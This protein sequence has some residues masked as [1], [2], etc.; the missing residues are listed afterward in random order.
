MIIL[1]DFGLSHRKSVSI[2]M[3][4]F[5]QTADKCHSVTDRY[6]EGGGETPP[7]PSERGGREQEGLGKVS[8]MTEGIKNE[9]L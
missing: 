6:Q 3:V 2:Y 7:T 4:Q 5:C 9:E 8:A 1:Q